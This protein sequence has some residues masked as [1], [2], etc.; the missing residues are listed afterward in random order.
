MMRLININLTLGNN[1]I[2]D[3]ITLAVTP[4]EFVVLAGPNG[5]GK[6][7]ALKVLSGEHLAD[8]GAVK[9]GDDNLDRWSLEEQARIRSVLPQDFQLNFNLSA[10]EVVLLG[11]LPHEGLTT[12]KR[13]VEVAHACLELT[14][15]TH[16]ATRSFPTLSGGEKQRVQLA[17]IL[18]QIWE[19]MENARPHYLLL[20]EPTASLDIEHQLLILELARSFAMKGAGVLA[21]LHDLNLSA[22]YADKLILM[23]NGRIIESGEP[24]HILTPEVIDKVFNVQMTKEWSEAE[25]TH[26]YLP[27]SISKPP[28][29]LS[30]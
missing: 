11:R 21:V 9:L 8:N 5:A 7:S 4:G 13:N 20:D 19:A 1:K 14:D 30:G 28:A 12:K 10:L 27:K 26:Y 18:A 16:L 24:Q 22:N 3:D 23:K 25:K 29:T 17:R 2:L 15:A 6:S